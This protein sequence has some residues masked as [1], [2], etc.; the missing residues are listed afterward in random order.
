MFYQK[1]FFTEAPNWLTAL[2]IWENL[3]F[4]KTKFQI[5]QTT[6]QPTKMADIE[7]IDT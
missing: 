1:V 7:T 5:I 6:K 4:G 3:F 2:V